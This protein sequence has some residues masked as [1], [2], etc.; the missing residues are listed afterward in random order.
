MA[1]IPGTPCPGCGEA[2]SADDIFCKHCFTMNPMVRNFLN[3][4]PKQHPKDYLT[5]DSTCPYCGK[6]QPKRVIDEYLPQKI[7]TPIHRCKK[8]SGYYANPDSL[9]WCV[10]PP[11]SKK[12]FR[13]LNELLV[14]NEYN[15]VETLIDSPL[16][17]AVTAFL[18]LLLHYPLWLLWLSFTLPKA[19]RNSNLRLERNP[20]YPQIL[21]IMG[22]G[23]YMDE[24]YNTLFDAPP[25]KQSFKDFLKEAFTFK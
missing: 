24:N 15:I 13:L 21:S 4:N 9:E 2:L 17:C 10:A 11:A 14:R 18:Y 20:D 7:R 12:K 8:C 5:V 19:I 22:Y 16:V 23:I 6:G 25:Q 3:H 1:T